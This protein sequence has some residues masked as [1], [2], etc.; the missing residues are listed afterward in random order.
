[1]KGGP[2]AHTQDLSGFLKLLLAGLGVFHV[3]VVV[4]VFA[5]VAAPGRSVCLPLLVLAAALPRAGTLRAGSPATCLGPFLVASRVLGLLQVD[6]SLN[7][8]AT[9]EVVAPGAVD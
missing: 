7:L 2:A 8:L 1:M 3:F 5:L 4:F 6:E 9:L